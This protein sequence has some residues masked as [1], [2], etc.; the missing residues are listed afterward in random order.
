MKLNFIYFFYIITDTWL[1]VSFCNFENTVAEQSGLCGWLVLHV[2]NLF[3]SF[4]FG[5]KLAQ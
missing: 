4:C 2:T 5:L 1:V 3:I